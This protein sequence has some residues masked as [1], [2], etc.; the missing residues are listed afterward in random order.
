MIS[1]QHTGPRAIFV[2]GD[3]TGRTAYILGYGGLHLVN[4][5]DVDK[6]AVF[7]TSEIK[8]GTDPG[9]GLPILLQAPIE[10]TGTHII[11]RAA[12]AETEGYVYIARGNTVQMIDATH[13][14]GVADSVPNKTTIAQGANYVV[15][16]DKHA[17]VTTDSTL[18]ILNLDP[19]NRP[20]LQYTVQLA[21]A[22]SVAVD[23]GYAYVATN[24]GVSI[25]ELSARQDRRPVVL[26]DIALSGT[27]IG[28]LVAG[29]TL[30][31]IN[32]NKLQAIDISDR[33]DP[34]LMGAI[35]LPSGVISVSLVGSYL[36]VAIAH[37]STRAA[38]NIYM[39]Q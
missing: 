38:L 6:P 29:Q 39:L 20:R 9:S 8:I 32:S 14:N 15:I 25:I 18:E 7:G 1:G 28:V 26:T 13:R 22:Q 5:T 4:V 33:N 2:D 37:S 34:R 23:G 31:I 24:A 36:Y 16:V 12:V 21:K 35:E 10:T 30:Y 11:Y 3:V 17:Y 19:P 27:P